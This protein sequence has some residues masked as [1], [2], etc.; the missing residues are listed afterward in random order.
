M[1][2]FGVVILPLLACGGSG[3]LSAEAAQGQRLFAANCALCHGQNAEGKAMLGKSLQTNGFVRNLSDEEIVGFLKTGRRADH[4]LNERGV[5]MPPK[6]GNPGLTDEDL[7]N[8]VAYLRAL[9]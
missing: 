1:A 9:S 8:I 3:D 6:G 7:Q 5:D 4:P 2:L